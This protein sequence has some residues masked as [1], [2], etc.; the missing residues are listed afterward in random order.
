MV[1]GQIIFNESEFL[2][3]HWGENLPTMGIGSYHVKETKS[4]SKKIDGGGTDWGRRHA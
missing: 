2:E 3:L 1:D 4:K